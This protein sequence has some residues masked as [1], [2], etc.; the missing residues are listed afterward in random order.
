[1]IPVVKKDEKGIYTLYVNDKP[2]FC[3]AGEL[4]NS[5]A[6]SLDY[7]NREVWPYLKDLHMNSVIVPL[8]W[9]SIE[10]E[11]GRF[12]FS[13][14]EGLIDQARENQ[15][16]LIFLWFG[17]WKNAESM[18]VPGWMK[19]DTATYFRA[20]KVNG[21]AINTISPLCQAAIDK[22]AKAFAA[23]MGRIKEIDSEEN[24]VIIMQ[25]ENEIGLLG[26]ERDYCDLANEKFTREIPADLTE[27]LNLAPG[28]TWSEAFGDDAPESF[29]A[30]YFARAVEQI[31]SAGQ[32]E[33]P[34]PCYT[35]SWLKQYPWYAGSYPSGGPIPEVHNI[36]KAM[37]PSLFTLAPDI[38]VPYVP[39]IMDEYTQPENPLFI[40]EVRKD[41][42]SAAYCLY[43]FGQHN[44]I[45]YSPFSIEELNMDPGLIETPPME[46]M[47][48]LNID[49]T[50]FDIAG[51]AAYLS[52]AYE[53]IGQIQPLY[54]KYRGTNKLRSYV[55]KSETDF[56][57]YMTFENYNL[58]I[59]Y[60]PRQ[61]QKPVAGG[62]IYELS[63]NKFL[64][65]GMQSTFTFTAKPGENLKVD[66]LK[67]EEG[68]IVDGK[69]QPGRTLNGDEKMMIKL[70]DMPACV[71][72]ELFK[73]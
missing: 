64:L 68:N 54:L 28:Q 4:H 10:P 67:M 16:K 35:N 21:E 36:W 61:P 37:A 25:V 20:R 38:Y 53:L 8:Y 34:L 70:G 59:A 13:L 46:L 1:M 42:V 3:L 45:C 7:M 44:A 50:A 19:K 51:S 27:K 6:S 48:A 62:M 33:Y 72:V 56:G 40:P 63:E 39:A 5:S 47:V 18:Y 65:V 58:S 71:M 9:E 32:A 31:S 23:V 2:F 57:T 12:D 41:A 55:K 52:R 17:L 43:A 14:P 29:M 11:E 60:A 22:D 24:T 26:T 15:M 69:W 30:Y 49:P 73:Y 66:V